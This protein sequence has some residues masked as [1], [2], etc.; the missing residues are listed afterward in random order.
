[1]PLSETF[2]SAARGTGKENVIE[3]EIP[4][5]KTCSLL[6]PGFTA[7]QMAAVAAAIYC[8]ATSNKYGK[9]FRDTQTLDIFSEIAERVTILLLIANITLCWQPSEPKTWD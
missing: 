5:F 4:S 9:F 8:M 7:S 1:M 6:S 3:N 2:K